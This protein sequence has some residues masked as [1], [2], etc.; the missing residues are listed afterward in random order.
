MNTKNKLV[1]VAAAALMVACGGGGSD[2]APSHATPLAAMGALRAKAKSLATTQTVTPAQAAEQLFA[3]GEQN[4]PQFFPG[5]KVTATIGPFAYRY[6]PETGMY[7]GVVIEQGSQWEYMSVYVTGGP[8]GTD[9]LNAGAL[10][11]Y[12]T[13]VDPNPGPTGTGNGCYDLALTDTAGTHINVVY[14]YSGTYQGAETGTQT[15]DSV[16]GGQ[17]AFEGHMG[18][19]TSTHT[20]G[21]LSGQATD[22]TLKSYATRSAD[23]ETTLYGSVE[24]SMSG[25]FTSIFKAVWSPPYVDPTSSLVAGTSVN[26]V[27][28]GDL[29]STFNSQSS[30]FHASTIFNTAYIGRESVT[31][32]AGTFS[33]CKIE[34]R[35][36]QSDGIVRPTDDVVT[37][38]VIVGT[39][40]VVKTTAQSVP[41]VFTTQATSVK[42]NGTQL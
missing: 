13:P 24:T 8:L 6:Y 2:P 35:E 1:A 37:T 14:D 9:L 3:W 22:V 23:T 18:R 7:L 25:G 36:L 29:T 32:P 33:A 40:I 27:Q 28:T 30:I 5:H 10:T 11:N 41:G 16:V 34:T 20:F 17:V 39:G 26:T 4:L 19:E 21:T 15:V 31:V 42:L 38:W 12:V